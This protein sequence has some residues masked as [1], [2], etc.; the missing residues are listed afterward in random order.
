[1]RDLHDCRRHVLLLFLAWNDNIDTVIKT[2][3]IMW[4]IIAVCLFVI[5][6]TSTIIIFYK[7]SRL[8]KC[9]PSHGCSA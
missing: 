1:M 5:I 8:Q 3:I 4:F 2:C 6:A 7:C 9:R